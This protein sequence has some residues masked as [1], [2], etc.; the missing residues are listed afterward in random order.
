[1][2]EPPPLPPAAPPARGVPE[3]RA[4]G[5]GELIEAGMRLY[6][7]RWRIFVPVAAV[8]MVPYAAL[9]AIASA[10]TVSEL[11][12]SAF[13]TNPNA[14]P[15]PEDLVAFFGPL[16]LIGLLFLLVYPVMVGALSWAAARTYLGE[17]PTP[18]QV[19]RFAI[20]RF[21]ALLWVTVLPF[22]AV[23]LIALVLFPVAFLV[24]N[25][26]VA[27]MLAVVFGIAAFVVF[28]GFLF[29]SIVV[30]VEDIRGTKALG[31]SWSL[32]KGFF[33]KVVGTT[34]L[35]AIISFIVEAVFSMPLTFISQSLLAGEAV[36][37]GSLLAFI[38]AA[39]SGTL[40]T[41]FSAIVQVLL[42]FDL[43]IRKEGMDLSL[44]AQQ[45]GGGGLEAVP[46]SAEGSGLD[47]TP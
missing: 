17:V 28:V 47:A 26:F 15:T 31:R 19:L 11:G 20:S 34:L 21:G 5:A 38:G 6:F 3:F 44:M 1:M 9:S 30:V 46:P 36:L 4:R 29:S 12:D 18:G 23:L 13:L 14:I 39:I 32:V 37:I 33:W 22:L 42:Y 25:G 35:A 2:D 41:P 8:F 45:L 40:V 16:M 7:A 27:F 10:V 43:R 24:D